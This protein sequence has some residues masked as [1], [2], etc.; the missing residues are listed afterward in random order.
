[1]PGRVVMV[2]D[3]L[4][5]IL[6]GLERAGRRDTLILIQDGA[7]LVCAGIPA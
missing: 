1:M 6:K 2:T 4:L 5:D 3:S 7:K